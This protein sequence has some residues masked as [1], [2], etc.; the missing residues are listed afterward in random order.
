MLE[1]APSVAALGDLTNIPNYRDIQKALH[2]KDGK[3]P[4]RFTLF[5]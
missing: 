5:S 4:K 1:S 2:S 3:L